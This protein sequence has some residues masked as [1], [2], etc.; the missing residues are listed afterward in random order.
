MRPP[1]C[2]PRGCN[3]IRPSPWWALDSAVRLR[4]RAKSEGTTSTSNNQEIGQ[5]VGA[6]EL[7][8]IT[9]HAPAA[10]LAMSARLLAGSALGGVDALYSF[11]QMPAGVPV[12]TMTVGPA[13]FVN[14]VVF[15]AQ[16]LARSKDRVGKRL[17]EFKQEL[18]GG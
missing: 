5:A 10:T 16:I 12:A 6:K 1:A 18:A 3:S 15:C 17:H 7:T 9:K 8:D 14:A 11:V 2:S 4:W 13:G